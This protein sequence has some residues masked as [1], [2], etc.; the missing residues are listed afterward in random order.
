MNNTINILQINIRGMVSSE[1]KYRKCPKL[2]NIIKSKTFRAV[3]TFGLKR[4]YRKDF[5]SLEEFKLQLVAVQKMIFRRF[6][7]H[8]STKI[9][10]CDISIPYVICGSNCSDLEGL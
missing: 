7:I 10:N 5:I 1:T 6:N 8:L 9:A 2:M 3:A 4:G